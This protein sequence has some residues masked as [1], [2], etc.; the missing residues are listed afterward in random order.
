M[1]S[2]RCVCIDIG[3]KFTKYTSWSKT[4]SSTDGD[5]ITCPTVVKWSCNGLVALKEEKSEYGFDEPFVKNFM[6]LVGKT[7]TDYQNSG[8]DPTTFGCKVKG[9]E[10]DEIVFQFTDKVSKSLNEVVIAVI[11]KVMNSCGYEVIKNII[12]TIPH[13]YTRRQIGILSKCVERAN[14]TLIGTLSHPM[15]SSIYNILSADHLTKSSA[16]FLICDCGYNSVGVSLIQYKENE[17]KMI[18]NARTER[19]SER[20]IDEELAK[21]AVDDFV[22]WNGDEEFNEDLED[23]NST[24]HRHLVQ[25]ISEW[26]HGDLEEDV[27][28]WSK[29]ENQFDI[30]VDKNDLYDLHKRFMNNVLVVVEKLLKNLEIIPFSGGAFSSNAITH[31]ILSGFFCHIGNSGEYFRNNLNP[32]AQVLYSKHDSHALFGAKLLLAQK[33]S[34]SKPKLKI[35]NERMY[36]IGLGVASDKVY[37]LFSPDEKLPCKKSL[38]IHHTGRATGIVSTGICIGGVLQGNDGKYVWS[39]VYHVSFESSNEFSEY[40]V[41]CTLDEIHLKLKIVGNGITVFQNMYII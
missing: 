34:K 8:Y 11:E 16:V 19:I 24:C 35:S 30:R 12:L 14:G 15:S 6:L 27:S 26:K 10:K 29:D 23:P 5:I 17:I 25:K 21:C 32:F 20:W 4:T 38:S 3:V 39:C 40:T 33:H 2:K 31:V 9:N 37:S 7:Y 1:S 18:G 41:H 13:D 36:Y 22:V 28:I